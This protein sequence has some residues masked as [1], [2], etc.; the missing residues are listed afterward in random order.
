MLRKQIKFEFIVIPHSGMKDRK[1]A[2]DIQSG[3][4]RLKT[5]FCLP[6][7]CLL[8][9]LPLIILLFWY[10]FVQV[11]PFQVE[12]VQKQQRVY[13]LNRL[14]PLTVFCKRIWRIERMESGLHH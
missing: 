9:F 8:S 11:M 13:P 12:S 4:N 7:F 10:R 6:F 1:T 5:F 14:D 3:W 2:F